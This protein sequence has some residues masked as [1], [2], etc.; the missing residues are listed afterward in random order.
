MSELIHVALEDPTLLGAALGPPDTWRTWITT[1]KAAFGIA[2]NR[3]ERRAFEAVAG[4]RTAPKERVRE[5]ICIIGRRS[6][7]SRVAA[8]VAAYIAVCVDHRDRLSAGEEGVVLVLAASRDQAHVVFNYIHAFLES[9]P[10]LAQQIDTVGA[11]TIRLKNNITI[12]VHSNSFRTVRGR[13]LVACI[14]DEAAFW[15]DETSATPDIETYRAVLP[16]LMTTKGMLVCISSPYR[17]LGLVFSK[18]RD[19]F[20]KNDDSVLVVQGASRDFNATLDE[21]AIA[22]ARADDPQGSLAEWDG[23]FRSDLAVC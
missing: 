8:A 12:A 17:R 19:C 7:K 5:L 6:G 15:R 22:A 10:I 1:L 14:F 9:S 20:G 18:H 3:Q 16:S 11:E 4:G 21:D 2:L 13:T 23:Q